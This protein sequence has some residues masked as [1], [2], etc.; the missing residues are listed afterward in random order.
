MIP[1]RWYLPFFLPSTALMIGIALS[2]LVVVVA[3]RMARRPGAT[4]TLGSAPWIRLRRLSIAAAATCTTLLWI[5]S[6]PVTALWC[7]RA[8]EA[9]YVPTDPASL[10]HAD[11]IVVLSGSIAT[12]VGP[13]GYM[14]V[15]MSS[16]VDRHETGLRAFFAGRAPI[17]A[18]G[19]GKPAFDGA[20]TEAEHARDRAIARGV[21]ADAIV[22]GA[23]A[24][25]T[26]D[27]CSNLAPLLRER[28]VEHII[29]CTSAHHMA[30]SIPHYRAAGFTVTPLPCHFL[31]RGEA[32]R[33]RWMKLV[34]TAAALETVDLCAKNWLGRIVGPKVEED[35]KD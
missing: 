18:L 15:R 20:P 8:T 7:I 10:P 1:T 22:V 30:R 5:A 14:H 6:M 31:T 27:E 35:S 2:L 25:F 24:N 12:T 34:P 32:E 28:G 33:F 23:G 29:L 17:L 16:A 3:T 21:P 4:G 11:A 26:S 9:P 19:N 13:D